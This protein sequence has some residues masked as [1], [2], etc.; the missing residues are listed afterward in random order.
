MADGD[1]EVVGSRGVHW[2]Q[3][4]DAPRSILHAYVQCDRIVSGVI[5]HICPEGSVPHRLRV[6]ILRAHTFASTFQEL[7]RHAGSRVAGRRTPIS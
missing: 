7:S 3:P 1:C 6:C 4:D 2:H 5:V